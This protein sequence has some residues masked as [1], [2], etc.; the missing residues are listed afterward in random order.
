VPENPHNRPRE[1]GALTTRNGMRT[2]I[3]IPA[4]GHVDAFTVTER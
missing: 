2:W 4:P 1:V 3:V